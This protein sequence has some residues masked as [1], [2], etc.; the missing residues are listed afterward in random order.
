MYF[1]CFT[2][3]TCTTRIFTFLRCCCCCCCYCCYIECWVLFASSR[4]QR[5]VACHMQNTTSADYYLPLL[6]LSIISTWFPLIGRHLKVPGER[7]CL[8]SQ[9][10]VLR[11]HSQNNL[12]NL[13]S[14]CVSVCLCVSVSFKA[15]LLCIHAKLAACRN[16]LL[17]NSSRLLVNNFVSLMRRRKI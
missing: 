12:F 1:T 8:S 14:M 5:N 11:T 2:V 17:N 10:S 13:F 15:C 3:F 16:L 9:F 6:L 4:Q 7:L